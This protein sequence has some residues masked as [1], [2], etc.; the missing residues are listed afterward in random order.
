[1]IQI[2]R[3][4]SFKIRRREEIEGLKADIDHQ[5]KTAADK[6]SVANS[7]L[8]KSITVTHNIAT[9]MGILK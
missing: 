1:M 4:I 8:R 2:V 3:S 5:S 7:S 6:I 9:A